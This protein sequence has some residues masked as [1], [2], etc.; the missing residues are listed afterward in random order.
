MLTCLLSTILF[1]FFLVML[2]CC[3]LLVVVEPQAHSK[4]HCFFTSVLSQF[5]ETLNEI[6]LADVRKQCTV[7]FSELV[8]LRPFSHYV[9]CAYT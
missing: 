4:V 1:S 9:Y 7:L 5:E 6:D 8:T 3:L 2:G